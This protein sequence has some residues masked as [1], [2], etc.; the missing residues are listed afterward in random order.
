MGWSDPNVEKTLLHSAVNLYSRIAAGM[1]PQLLMSTL[2]I[3]S[4]MNDILSVHIGVGVGVGTAV[5]A[6]AVDAGSMGLQEI[7]LQP[8]AGGPNLNW[9]AIGQFPSFSKLSRNFQAR[10]L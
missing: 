7:S 1:V 3:I 2:L 4:P 10:R 5:A 6:V 9:Q 8:S